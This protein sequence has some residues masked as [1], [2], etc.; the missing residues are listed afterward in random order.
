MDPT[1]KTQRIEEVKSALACI[2]ASTSPIPSARAIDLC[3]NV[4]M[5][6]NDITKDKMDKVKTWIELYDIQ[7]ATILPSGLILSPNHLTSSDK[8]YF[9]AQ[10]KV[11]EDFVEYAREYAS[12]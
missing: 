6:I 10:L 3:D 2:K 11:I 12:K 1:T 9:E 7:S 4:A 5:L 8:N